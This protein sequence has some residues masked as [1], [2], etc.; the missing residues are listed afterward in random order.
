MSPRPSHL[1]LSHVGLF[2]LP[3]PLPIPRPYPSPLHRLSLPPL[4]V[5]VRS[6]HVY[7]HRWLGAQYRHAGALRA[8]PLSSWSNRL[9]LFELISKLASVST[10]KYEVHILYLRPFNNKNKEVHVLYLRPFQQRWR[11]SRFVRASVSKQNLEVCGVSCLG[12]LENVDMLSSI[13][14]PGPQFSTCVVLARLAP[15]TPVPIACVSLNKL[16]NLRPSQ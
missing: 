4:T 12:H 3:S 7:F 9:R 10:N 8:W 14:W 6:E 13:H 2:P 16:L 15:I 11:S 5:S 1:P